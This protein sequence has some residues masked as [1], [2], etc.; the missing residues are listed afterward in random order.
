MHL[1]VRAMVQFAKKAYEPSLRESID[2]FKNG[3][4]YAVSYWSVQGG[5]PYQEDRHVERV[6]N[7]APDSSLYGVFDGHGGHNA[8]EF[9]KQHMVNNITS[10]EKFNEDVPGALYRAF[11]K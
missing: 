5:R 9:C 7:G 1:I 4:H 8:A 10:D 11:M 2:I 3:V 6:G